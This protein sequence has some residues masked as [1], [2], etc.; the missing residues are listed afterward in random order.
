MVRLII[1]IVPCDTAHCSSVLEDKTSKVA[2][3]TYTV[4]YMYEYSLFF[5][6]IP[7][8]NSKVSLLW[9]LQQ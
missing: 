4:L 8:L 9:W 5:R 1:A 3:S 2:R 6:H 7:Y